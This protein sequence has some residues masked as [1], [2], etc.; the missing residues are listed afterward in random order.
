MRKEIR[1]NPFIELFDESVEDAQREYGDPTTGIN[2]LYKELKKALK[3]VEV[4]C[5]GGVMETEETISA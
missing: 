2:I 4:K 5:R 1:P 3:E